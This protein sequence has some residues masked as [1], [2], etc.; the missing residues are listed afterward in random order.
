MSG[1]DRQDSG[2][3]QQG[4]S[5]QGGSQQGGS[6]Q[7]GS[8]QGG[9]SSGGGWGDNSGLGRVQKDEHGGRRG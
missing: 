3:S 4:G 7:G 9:G 8:Q 6:Q 2:G 1:N 5:Q